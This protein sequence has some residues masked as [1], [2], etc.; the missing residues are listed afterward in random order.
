MNQVF[1]TTKPTESRPTKPTSYKGLYAFHKYWGKKPHEP[2]A[3][4]IKLLTEPNQ[5]VA[6]PFVG[7]GTTAREAVLHSRRFIGMDINPIATELTRLLV[8]P[9]HV[10]DLQLGATQI[11]QLAKRKILESYTLEQANNF[12]SHYLW[13]QD[14]LSNVWFL[15]GKKR[16]EVRP[17]KFDHTLSNSFSDYRSADIRGPQFFKNSRIN[18]TPSMTTSDILSGRAQRNIDILIEAIR[19]CPANIQP[20][21]MLCLTA[22]S[23]QMSKMVFA[24]TGRGKRSGQTSQRVEV[25]SWVIGYWRPPLHFE[26]NVWNCFESRLSKLLKAVATETLMPKPTLSTEPLDVLTGHSSASVSLGDSRAFLR[27]MPDNSL[28]LI[29]ADPPHGDRIPYLELSELWNGIL[30]QP[31]NFDD[32]IVISNAQER[33]KTSAQYINSL[34]CLFHDASRL[35]TV[36][37]SFVFIFNARQSK[38]WPA[39][40]NLMPNLQSTKNIPFRYLGYFPCTYS[41]GSVVQ[42]NRPGSLNS[43]YVMVFA[44]SNCNPSKRLNSLVTLPG[45]SSDLPEKLK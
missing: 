1:P 32:E 17:T 20:A 2:V 10:Q 21:L 5:I 19:T 25:G 34:E 37:G 45:W 24:I 28:D 18:T 29:I 42:D 39:I 43:D 35:L 6:D 9:P 15:S 4:I 33:K 26:I 41:A 36:D 8:C 13:D 11:E 31:V 27:A 38:W 30:G 16:V 23:G 44:K 22:A 7:S 3:E 12:A 14:T 40:S